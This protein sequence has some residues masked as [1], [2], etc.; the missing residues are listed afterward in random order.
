MPCCALAVLSGARQQIYCLVCGCV[1]QLV[2]LVV[3]VNVM[4][5][6]SISY[7][8]LTVESGVDL[9]ALGLSLEMQEP[10]FYVFIK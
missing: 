8:S 5:T 9:N 6:R 7:G 4:I 1:E 2:A 3:L 10:H